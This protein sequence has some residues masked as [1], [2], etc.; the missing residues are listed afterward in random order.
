MGIHENDWKDKSVEQ[1]YE[2]EIYPH[3]TDLEILRKKCQKYLLGTIAVGL[4]IGVIAVSFENE[5][6]ETMQAVSGGF[7][8]L[9][10]VAM[11]IGGYKCWKLYQELRIHYKEQVVH[12]VINCFGP[13]LTYNWQNFVDKHDF[14]YSN[15]F[16][17]YIDF[18]KGEDHVSGHREQ[19]PFE[20]SEIDAQKEEVYYEDGKKRKRKV[21]IFQGLFFRASFNKHIQGETLVFP[22][23]AESMFGSLVGN[24]LQSAN[25]EHAG[26]L[27]KLEDVEFEK[28]FAVYGTDQIEARYILTPSMMREM[29]NLS[30]KIKRPLYFSFK[31]SHF[32]NA[33][34]KAFNTRKFSI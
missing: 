23:L 20:F 33:S 28:K 29:T 4:I 34:K 31:G 15:L 30:N 14:I 21:T 25:G 32:E 9:S 24:F 6:D 19:V 13:N 16:K 2:S 12:K 10:L 26:K 18:Y 11:A 8:A 1:I 22:D 17:E 3:L 5:T 27:V 7:M